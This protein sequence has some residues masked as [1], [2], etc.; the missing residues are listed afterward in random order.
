MN[1]MNC[2]K[3][4]KYDL[5]VNNLKTFRTLETKQMMLLIKMLRKKP[6]R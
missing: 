2:L 1:G 6:R 4:E 5:D 3:T